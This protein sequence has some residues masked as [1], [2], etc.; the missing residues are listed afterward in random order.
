MGDGSFAPDNPVTRQDAAVMIARLCEKK[1]IAL[2]GK[3]ATADSDKIAS[4]A[5][6]SVEK[7]VGAG[8]ISGFEDGSFRPAENL[9]RAQA[10]KLICVL[11]EK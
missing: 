3:G 4:Y 9:T 2:S 10:A 1:G 7:L 8:I 6:E 5:L 11:L